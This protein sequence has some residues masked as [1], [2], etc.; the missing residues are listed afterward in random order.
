MPLV[1]SRLLPSH[2]STHYTQDPR[3]RGIFRSPAWASIQLDAIDAIDAMLLRCFRVPLLH[4]YP[5]SN[6][7]SSVESEQAGLRPF[8]P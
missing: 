2:L 3:L 5:V 7:D 1:S 4:L 8:T 6:V